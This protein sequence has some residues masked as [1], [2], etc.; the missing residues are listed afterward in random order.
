VKYYKNEEMCVV[1]SSTST[2]LQGPTW[3]DTN[4]LP[5]SE[6]FPVVL[7]ILLIKGD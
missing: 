3:N 6:F 7:L 4:V 2:T 5:A 1:W